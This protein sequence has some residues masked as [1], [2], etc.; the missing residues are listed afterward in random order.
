VTEVLLVLGMTAGAFV[1]T[2]LDNFVLLVALN[3]RYDE[4]PAQVAAGYLGG[5]LLVGALA[6]AAGK[7]A[8]NAPV[9]YLGYLGLVP[10]AIGI[11]ALVRL[12][13]GGAAQAPGPTSGGAALVATLTTQLS[14]GTDTAV[15]FAILYADSNDVADYLVALAFCCML[16]VF[17]AAARHATRH[18]WMRRPLERYGRYATPFILIAVGFFVIS[19]SGLDTMPGT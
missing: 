16:C 9:Q 12:F 6:L 11:A 17:A 4:H 1:A 7:L 14:N 5:M 8:G 2:N 13:R 10:I 15:T 19:N 3:A 18:E